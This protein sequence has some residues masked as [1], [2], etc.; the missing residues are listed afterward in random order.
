MGTNTWAIRV[1]DE[2]DDG[3]AY[4]GTRTGFD[5]L[6][7]M[8]THEEIVQQLEAELAK[9][10]QPALWKDEQSETLCAEV[11]WLMSLE[12]AE[13]QVR[14]L[15]LSR[16]M[17]LIHEVIDAVGRGKGWQLFDA[18]SGTRIHRLG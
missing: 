2:V 7:P 12:K 4:L 13:G 1:P 14:M 16:P 18:G 10:G 6:L 3:W 9:R 15:Q 11:G 8:G 17:P 5:D